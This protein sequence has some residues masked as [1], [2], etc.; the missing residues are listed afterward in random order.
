[1]PADRRPNGTMLPGNTANPG[2]RPRKS[3]NLLTLFDEKRDEKVSLKLENGRTVKMSRMEAWVTNLWN[4]AIALDPKA[5]LQIMAI[6][7][8]SGQL[9]PSPEEA[10]DLDPDNRAVLD[11][12]IGRL[13]AKAG[14]G[15][16][17]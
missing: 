1:M 3:R 2:G 13:I 16:Q 15:E 11:A 5:S 9:T 7:R 14:D 8:A 12:V 17:Q 10:D 4:K 6:M